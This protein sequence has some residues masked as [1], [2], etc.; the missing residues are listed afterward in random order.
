VTAPWGDLGKPGHVNRDS[1]W[2][3]LLDYVGGAPFAMMRQTSAQSLTNGAGTNITFDT[4]DFDNYDGHSTSLN[5]SRYTAQ[6]AGIYQLGGG[7]CFAANTAGRRGGWFL[8]NGS[9]IA[10]SEAITTTT[11]SATCDVPM[12]VTFV[13]LA[14]TDFVELAAFQD[15]GGAL[16][17]SV[18]SAQQHPTMTIRWIA[19]V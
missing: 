7:V 10:G 6:V 11:A 15:S 12:R 18:A 5:T 17:T 4:A 2:E 16:N 13:S 9:I 8:K 1:E 19:L 14:V 3:A